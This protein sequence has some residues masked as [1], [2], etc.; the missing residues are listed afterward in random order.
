MPY[1]SIK[2][3]RN[4]KKVVIKLSDIPVLPRTRPESYSIPDNKLSNS[5]VIKTGLEMSESQLY[6]DCEMNS[7]IIYIPESIVELD[8][9]NSQACMKSKYYPEPKYPPVILTS[10]VTMNKKVKLSPLASEMYGRWKLPSINQ[11]ENIF[12]SS[13]KI[14]H[15]APLN[16]P[17][18]PEI[19]PIQS[20]DPGGNEMSQDERQ[21]WYSQ[22][23]RGKFGT[24]VK[25]NQPKKKRRSGF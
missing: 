1:K 20:Q 5:I 4:A 22:P 18:V 7:K 21:V 12:N 19:F 2:K 13:S 16:L 11:E 14:R 3:R 10:P 15:H 24:T 8:P 25:D 6:C 17:T 9:N 23:V